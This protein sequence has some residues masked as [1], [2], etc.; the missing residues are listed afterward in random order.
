MKGRQTALRR[1]E[2]YEMKYYSYIIGMHTS[3]LGLR[4]KCVQRVG[5]VQQGY[6]LTDVE[7]GQLV[8]RMDVDRNG[9]VTFDEFATCLLDW[10]DFKGGER[11]KK[12]VERAFKKLDLN[13]DGYISLEEL[14]QLLPD[15]YE[16]S[17]QR[18]SAARAMM[19]EF[20]AST[21]GL[22]SWKEFYHMLS[23]M[24]SQHALEYYD[25]RFST[26]AIGE[27]KQEVTLA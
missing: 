13:G 15:A 4:L 5:L 17:E 3:V 6:T 26:E 25:R 22:I 21:D 18:Q 11:W 23:D 10:Q 12:L 8:S 14:M 27:N 16:T 9:R 24:S 19:R 20:D 1:T 7:V 2:I